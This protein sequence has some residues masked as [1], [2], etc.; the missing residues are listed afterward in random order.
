VRIDRRAEGVSHQDHPVTVHDHHLGA[1]QITKHVARE[2][3]L[4][5]PFR[6]HAAVHADQHRD[7]RGHRVQVVRRQHDRDPFVVEL[8]EQVQDIVP[9]RDVDPGRRLIK[10]KQVRLADE[11]PGDERPLLLA[12]RKIADM[13]PRERGDPELFEYVASS[14]AHLAR[15]PRQNPCVAPGAEKDDL[16]DGDRERP[17]DGF[18][19]RNDGETRTVLSVASSLDRAARRPDRALHQPE[20]RRLACSGGPHHSIEATF[21]D[22]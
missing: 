15:R 12:P 13:T 8:V 3:L 11:C 21:A 19:L 7:V 2:D 1:V 22:R 20:Q 10:Q 6:D 5:R 4:R 18:K 9:R 14:L 17:I 16:L